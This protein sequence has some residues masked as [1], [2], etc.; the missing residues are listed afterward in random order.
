MGLCYLLYGG[1]FVDLKL[2]YYNDGSGL[3][4]PGESVY[5]NK[6]TEKSKSHLHAHDFIEIAYVASGEG[7]HRI[8][9]KEY[10][11]SRGDLF[12]I[13]Y[14][15]PHEFRSFPEPEKPGLVVYNCIFKPEFIDYTLINCNDFYDIT[16]HFLFQSLFPY[17]DEEP[18]RIKIS[19]DECDEIE[20]LYGKMLM[21]YTQMKAGYIEIIRA[22]TI[23]LLV[24][25]FRL[26][27]A[28]SNVEDK[29]TV[30]RKQ[31]IENVMRYL[32]ENYNKNLK[33][34]DLAMMY[35]FSR[36]YFCKLFRE[37]TGMTVSEYIQKIRIQEACRLLRQTRKT[38]LEIL[39]LV[40]YKDIKFFNNVFKRN[41]GET[42]GN[43]RKKYGVYNEVNAVDEKGG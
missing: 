21:E 12:I 29:I 13:N 18:D 24:T 35:F 30:K 31:M 14:D 23:E 26:L 40:G 34:E 20:N 27:K 3:F 37:V 25:I 1:I 38:V 39:Q 15:V 19:P 17:E 6:V 10:S 42:P 7:I 33:L 9:D 2:K 11:V 36:S 8:G 41:T 22:Y 32:K 28:R 43:Y 4:R 5:I 16:H